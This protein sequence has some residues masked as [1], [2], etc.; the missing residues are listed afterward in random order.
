[1][2]EGL[3][4]GLAPQVP[5]E[6]IGREGRPMLSPHLLWRPETA[7]L[8]NKYEIE[9]SEE[10]GGASTAELGPVPAMAISRCPKRRPL[11]LG[12]WQ[13]EGPGQSGEKGAAGVCGGSQAPDSTG[14]GGAQS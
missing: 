8:E 6:V 3:V 2:K 9:S 13:Q 5:S 12:G 10:Q 11:G 14:D 4:W 1:M 7:L